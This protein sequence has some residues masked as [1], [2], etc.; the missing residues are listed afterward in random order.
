LKSNDAR[1]FAMTAAMSIEMHKENNSMTEVKVEKNKSLARRETPGLSPFNEFFTPMFPTGGF[2]GLS[3]FAIMRGFSE[4]L[5]RLYRANAPALE[6]WTPTV[7]IQQSNDDLVVTVELPGLKK[8][9]VKVEVTDDPL[10]IEGERKREHKVEQEGYYRYE[11]NFGRFYRSIPLP[12]GA[13]P[14]QAKA[15]L[16]DGVLKISVPAPHQRC[17]RGSCRNPDRLRPQL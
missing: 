14:D 8:E 2:F 13:K 12:E 11:R 1:N 3:P 17:R 5:D 10:I 16:N 7:D 4:E 6:A 9:E 15:E